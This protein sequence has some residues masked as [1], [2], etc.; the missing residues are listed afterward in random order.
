LLLLPQR[1]CSGILSLLI[2]N[3]RITS[4]VTSVNSYL[5]TSFRVLERTAKHIASCSTEP[6]LSYCHSVKRKMSSILGYISSSV[7]IETDRQTDRRSVRFVMPLTSPTAAS[8]VALGGG[9]VS[10]RRQPHIISFFIHEMH[11]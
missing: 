2:P 1:I 8:W 7:A 4:L 6:T 10:F 3:S 5:E 9:G 11:T